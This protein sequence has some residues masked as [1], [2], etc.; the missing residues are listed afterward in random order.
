M[1]ITALEDVSLDVEQGE[2][3]SI[4]GHSGSG[5]STLLS[6][7]GGILKQ[8]SGDILFN[9]SSISSLD[10]DGLAQY[11][12]DNIGH[13]FQFASLL[14]V[15]T[16]RENLI[17]PTIFRSRNGSSHDPELAERYLSMVGL[18][19][20]LD[21]FPSQLSGGQQRRVAI[22]RALMNQPELLLADEP[23]GDL[24]E[25]TEKEIMKLLE[26]IN[27][28]MN[29]TLILVTHCPELSKHSGRIL[30]MDHGQ[31]YKT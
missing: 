25:D 15:L 8:S 31:L 5:K 21:V 3:V 13:I 9:G 4:M 10:P 11:R 20:K 2:F 17:L 6:I 22:V 30:K 7:I 12:A 18:R 19:D 24:D 26:H 27:R 16:V 1:A 29:I 28:E 14:P 23:T